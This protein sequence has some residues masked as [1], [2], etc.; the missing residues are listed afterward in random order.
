[1]IDGKQN[2]IFQAGVGI[3]AVESRIRQ[4]ETMMAAMQANATTADPVRTSTFRQVLTQEANA[5]H[6]ITGA[7]NE[8]TA[9]QTPYALPEPPYPTAQEVW[10]VDAPSVRSGLP[11][12]G[13]GMGM[14]KQLY[15]PLIQHLSHTHGVDP[16]IIQAMVQQESAFNPVAV[17]KSG[18]RGLLQLMPA[19]AKHM[20]IANSFDPVQN[21]DGGI[22]Y[23][24]QQLNRFNGNIPLALAAYNAGP[25]AV[26]RHGGIPP[27]GETKQYVQKILANYLKSRNGLA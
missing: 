23:F 6:A 8:P 26:I 20:G 19:T 7:G 22:R 25:N 15:Q 16:G 17:S 14:R 27:Y 24:K 18:A 13:S 4:I 10:R 21:L 3:N 2:S 9:T 11:K 12:P 5:K 1:M